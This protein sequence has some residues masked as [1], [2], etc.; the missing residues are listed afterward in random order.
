MASR[1]VDGQDV[2]TLRDAFAK[3]IAAIR[4]DSL[5]RFLEIKTYRYAGHSR[6]DPALY[7]PEGEKDR[8]LER[9][10]INLATAAILKAG[11][12]DEALL[13]ELRLTVKARVVVAVQSAMDSPGPELSAMFANIIAEKTP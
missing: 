8:W 5:P 4:Q 13:N 9:D 10:P 7:R 2:E 1:A 3:E 12:A 6:T 11:L